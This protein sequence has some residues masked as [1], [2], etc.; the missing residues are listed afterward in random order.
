MARLALSLEPDVGDQDVAALLEA[1][2][3][4]AITAVVVPHLA[5]AK[6]R[7]PRGLAGAALAAGRQADRHVH[8]AT[9]LGARR[10]EHRLVGRLRAAAAGALVPVGVLVVVLDAGV[11]RAAADGAAIG[12]AATRRLQ[13]TGRLEGRAARLDGAARLAAMTMMTKTGLGNTEGEHRGDGGTER[14]QADHGRRL[15][16]RKGPPNP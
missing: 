14:K 2:D 9:G 13:G 3:H 11:R 5:A 15:R 8:R 4:R 6:Q 10:G 7:A 16:R 1:D 12:L